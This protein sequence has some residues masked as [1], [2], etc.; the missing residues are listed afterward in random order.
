[1]NETRPTVAPTVR[2]FL[3]ER[4]I[5]LEVPVYGCMELRAS[6]LKIRFPVPAREI[7]WL[8]V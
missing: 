7:H 4:L 2:V 6:R 5:A 8:L 3:E 1:M